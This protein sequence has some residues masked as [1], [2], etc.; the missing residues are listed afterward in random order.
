MGL[1]EPDFS[2][3]SHSLLSDFCDVDAANLLM[4]SHLCNGRIF[5]ANCGLVCVKSIC[6]KIDVFKLGQLDL[7]GSVNC[8]AIDREVIWIA[9]RHA[10]A[11]FWFW[12]FSL[13]KLGVCGAFGHFSVGEFELKCYLI[14]V[15]F[16]VHVR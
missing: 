8:D 9:E 6:G 10:T 3:F 7:F 15:M 16:V 1:I 2:D 13:M 5:C 12:E 11:L 4:K 14:C